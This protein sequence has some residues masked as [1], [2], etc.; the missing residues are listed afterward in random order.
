MAVRQRLSEPLPRVSS[1]RVIGFGRRLMTHN[2]GVSEWKEGSLGRLK[3]NFNVASGN[4]SFS[5][6]FSSVSVGS[7]LLTEGG[8]WSAV[9]SGGVFKATWLNSASL[10]I[11]S[12]FRSCPH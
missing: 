5:E 12:M 4:K 3:A 11:I 7:R 9:A 8:R 1:P 2:R 6:L 10:S